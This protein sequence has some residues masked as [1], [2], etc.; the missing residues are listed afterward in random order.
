MSAE[1]AFSILIKRVLL[2]ARAG[3]YAT[4]ATG[5]K[6]KEKIL[7]SLDHD[8]EKSLRPNIGRPT[9][10]TKEWSGPCFAF[11]Q[12]LDFGTEFSSLRNAYEKLRDDDG[13]LLVA[14]DGSA[15]IYRPES[16]W[17]AEI[18]L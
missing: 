2:P 11:H 7:A 16:R 1:Q 4:L 9:A 13:W 8:F 15:A 18:V 10:Q 12:S 14:A 5:N 17:D 6:G 3:R